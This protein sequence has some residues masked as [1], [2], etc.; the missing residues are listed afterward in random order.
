MKETLIFLHFQGFFKLYNA[1]YSQA[2]LKKIT[3]VHDLFKLHI[4]SKSKERLHL[5]QRFA[6]YN[7]LIV[8]FAVFLFGG[9]LILLFLYPI[10]IYIFEEK[11]ALLFF[12]FVPG[13]DH[14]TVKGYF[15]IL[16]MHLMVAVL[17]AVGMAGCDIFYSVLI[18]NVPIMARLLQDEVIALNVNL[19][20]SAK[21]KNTWNHQFRNIILMHQETIT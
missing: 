10:C 17:G 14:T 20:Q 9:A 5:F 15:L 18:A 7:D 21:G 13:I 12:V 4:N 11:R 6:F 16:A 3:F 19:K 2:F 8:K 1:R